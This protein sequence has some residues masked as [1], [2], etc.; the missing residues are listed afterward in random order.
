MSNLA[1]DTAENRRKSIEK[2]ISG[3]K[4]AV[5]CRDTQ[6]LKQSCSKYGSL[7]RENFSFLEKPFPWAFQNLNYY[8]RM[9]RVIQHTRSCPRKKTGQQGPCSIC[10]QV[11]DFTWGITWVILLRRFAN[12]PNSIKQNDCIWLKWDVKNS[13]F[14]CIKYIVF[15]Q[16]SL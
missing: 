12:F 9:K 14:K 11:R 6:C 15:C 5:V 4:H 3:L 10:K 1:Q 7:F 16:N 2:C 13:A 8:L